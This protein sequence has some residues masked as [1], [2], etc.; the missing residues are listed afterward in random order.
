MRFLIGETGA[1]WGDRRR[2]RAGFFPRPLGRCP[3]DVARRC[4]PVWR[5]DP[6]RGAQLPVE[7]FA[8]FVSF[9]IAV[10]HTHPNGIATVLGSRR[11]PCLRSH[12]III[13]I[14]S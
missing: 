1:T 9:G 5:G 3:A 2:G 4:L 8:L 6:E 14:Y 13:G 7:V 11:K 12:L 10:G